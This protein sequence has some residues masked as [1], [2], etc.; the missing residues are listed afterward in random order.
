MN[1]Q[2]LMWGKGPRLHVNEGQSKSYQV[3]DEVLL[4]LAEHAHDEMHT[5]E[6][7]IG[8][9]TLLFAMNRCV[10]TCIAPIADEV[11]RI[12]DFAREKALPLDTVTFLID[13]SER[14]L[15]GLEGNALDLVLIDGAHGFPVPFIDWYYTADRLKVGGLLVLDDTQLWPVHVLKEFLLREPEWRL[16]KDFLPRSTVFRKTQPGSCVKNE[17]WQP[18]VVDRTIELLYPGHIDMIQPY[19]PADAIHDWERRER[20]GSLLNLRRARAFAK[21]VLRYLHR[22]L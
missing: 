7:G 5:L 22:K 19:L 9:S 3:A 1:V 15:P 6:T 12:R 4:F 16:E 18:Y 20:P 8:V 17:F 21:R 2:D 11:E 10:H 13:T 14:V